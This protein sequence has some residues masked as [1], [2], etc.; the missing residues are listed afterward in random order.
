LPLS[1]PASDANMAR[2]REELAGKGL[3]GRP[4]RVRANLARG[5]SFT[6]WAVGSVLHD[7]YVAAEKA[8]EVVARELDEKVPVGGDWHRRLLEQMT[9]A[10]PGVRP[11]LL[12]KETGQ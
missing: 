3:V 8:F 4:E 12:T 5:D 9:L 2:L 7:F 10:I 1:P 6:L 11:A